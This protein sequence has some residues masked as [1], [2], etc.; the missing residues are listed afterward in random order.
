MPPSLTKNSPV[1]YHG[2]FVASRK[3]RSLPGSREGVEYEQAGARTKSR[4]NVLDNSDL[5]GLQ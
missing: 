5:L 2:V 3:L 4:M 1:I